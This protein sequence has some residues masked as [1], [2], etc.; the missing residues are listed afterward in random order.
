MQELDRYKLDSNE[1]ALLSAEEMDAQMDADEAAALE[2]LRVI[3]E[4]FCDFVNAKAY[5]GDWYAEIVEGKV[6]VIN[7]VS[8]QATHEFEITGNCPIAH[9][10][11]RGSNW[12]SDAL[13]SYME[14]WAH[15]VSE[16]EA[17]KAAMKGGAK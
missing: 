4:D 14:D 10:G 3:A 8:D 15:H 2:S 17:K 5:F 1:D 11:A 7:D 16:R 13:A 6:L 9:R 12:F